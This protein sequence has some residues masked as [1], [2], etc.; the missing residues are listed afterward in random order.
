MAVP[1]EELPIGEET[2][3]IDLV[4]TDQMIDDYVAALEI[5]HDWFTTGPSPY[6]GRIA[7]P[8]MLPKLGM[9]ELFQKYLHRVM[10]ANMRAKQAFKFFAPVRA[11]M[12]VKATGHLAEKYE[13]RGKRFVTFEAL[14][15][16]ENG[17]PLVLDRR[18]QYLPQPKPETDKAAGETQ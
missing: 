14:F 18:T 1:W 7:P 15:T 9:D 11:G 12:R 10:G 4:V 6:G 16:D 2:G 17:T 13:R 8:D 3:S 5:Q